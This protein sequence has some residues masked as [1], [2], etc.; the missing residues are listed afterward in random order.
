[1]S[2]RLLLLITFCVGILAACY[3]PSPSAYPNANQ[4]GYDGVSPPSQANPNGKGPPAD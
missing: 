2:L 3:G 4:Q 1:M